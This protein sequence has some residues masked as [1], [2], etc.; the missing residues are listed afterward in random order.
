MDNKQED[1]EF[2]LDSE[3]YAELDAAATT[4][5]YLCTEDRIINVSFVSKDISLS[6]KR[7]TRTDGR[8][9][10]G[11]DVCAYTI[12]YSDR[13]QRGWLDKVLK[14]LSFGLYKPI[15]CWVEVNTGVSVQA[16][17]P[18]VGFDG[19]MNSRASKP[20]FVLGNGLGTIDPGYTGDIRLI[21]D[22]FS[23]ATWEDLNGYFKQGSVVGQLV[24]IRSL[25]VKM[26]P[27]LFLTETD[28][29]AGGF[30]STEEKKN[31]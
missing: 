27:A 3:S 12:K 15:P 13:T 28:R 18:A 10:L 31:K 1:N 2:S 4:M 16:D 14:V 6:P 22:I 30:G 19:R 23:W 7:R 9:D 20:P 11:W 5:E 24:P 8:D 17:D 26:H 29:S 21:F 25:K